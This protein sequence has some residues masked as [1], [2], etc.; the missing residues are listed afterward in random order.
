MSSRLRDASDFPIGTRVITPL[1]EP[2]VVEGH[3]CAESKEDM[4]E[5]VVCRY[6]RHRG[7]D[8]GTVTLLPHLLK[9]ASDGPQRELF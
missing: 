2:A 1:G 9:L 6:E 8:R 7:Q 3:K 5:R 4:H